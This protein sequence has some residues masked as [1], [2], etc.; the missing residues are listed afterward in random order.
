MGAE[1]GPRPREIFYKGRVT[2]PL[3][4]RLRKI[5]ELIDAAA[6]RGETELMGK[7]DL[8]RLWEEMRL[9]ASKPP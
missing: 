9:G 6:E 5:R 3:G 2:S 4:F 7:D 8:D 1:L